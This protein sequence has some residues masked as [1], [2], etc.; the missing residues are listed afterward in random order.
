[1]L[2]FGILCVRTTQTRLSPRTFCTCSALFF[3]KMTENKVLW[4]IMGDLPEVISGQGHSISQG[5]MLSPAVAWA[6]P[7]ALQVSSRATSR[8]T[9]GLVFLAPREPPCGW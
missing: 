4:L 3:K 7:G 1:M 6:F 5:P 2:N 8:D 9:G